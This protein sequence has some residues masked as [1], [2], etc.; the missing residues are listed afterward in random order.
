LL[1]SSSIPAKKRL[2]IIGLL[3]AEYGEPGES[4]EF[5]PLITQET[6]AEM[7]GTTRSRVSCFMNRFRKLR[8]IDY[9]GRI[10]V[11]KSLLKAFL[12]DRLPAHNLQLPRLADL[13]EISL[14]R[15]I[16]KIC[17]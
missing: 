6:L 7:I 4:T 2:A 9:N 1:I 12:L 10:Q 16:M 5:I 3:M 17:A 13:S 8:F 11:R 15:S 14:D